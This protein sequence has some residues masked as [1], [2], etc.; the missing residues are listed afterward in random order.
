MDTYE[1]FRRNFPFVVRSEETARDILGNSENKV[2]EKRND[3]GQLIG[4]SVLRGNTIYLLC[5]D[6][7]YRKQG[8]GTWLLE[9]SEKA[10]KS[11][12]YNEVIIGAGDDYLTPGVPTSKR[13]APA[14]NERLWDGL[15]ETASD[16]FEHRG[17]FHSWNACNC[18][19]MMFPLSDFEWEEHG[20]G[21]TIDGIRYRWATIG[22]L[23]EITA[24]TNEASEDFTRWY[25]EH[26]MYSGEG[27]SRVLIATCGDTVAGTLIVDVGI[28][29]DAVGSVGCTAVRPAFR[30]KHIAVNM[31]TLGT[32]YLKEM[33]MKDAFLSYT[34]SGLDHLYGYAGY[35]ICMYYLM[36][37]KKL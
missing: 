8:I 2:I 10:I 27:C 32:R 1:L 14:E 9:Q 6:K 33:G 3:K 18:F 16:F 35:K 28:E 24:C 17:Y 36:A 15:D 11:A 22:D 4:A 20:I 13:Y 19:D 21:D 34:Y 29:Q 5:V 25:Q 26:S 23:P 7:E 37:K 30:G 31:V 12:G